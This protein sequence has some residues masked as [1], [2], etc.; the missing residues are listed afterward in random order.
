MRVGVSPVLAVA[1]DGE[2]I[3]QPLPG[4]HL[5][6]RTARELAPPARVQFARQGELDLAVEPPVGA[7]MLVRRRP[8]RARV[9]LHPRG[10]VAVLHML[11]F[12]AVSGIAPIALDVIILGAGGLPVGAGTETDLE[13]IDRHAVTSVVVQTH[14]VSLRE[15]GIVCL[16]LSFGLFCHASPSVDLNYRPS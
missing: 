16:S 2:R 8:V 14:A 5:A 3:G 13:V 7:L 6:R 9:L 10:H 4:A 1:V 12:I 15:T 11:E